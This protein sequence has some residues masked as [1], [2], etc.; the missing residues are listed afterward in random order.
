[1]LA[2]MG[3]IARR[4]SQLSEAQAYLTRALALKVVSHH[5]TTRLLGI[6]VQIAVEQSD[7]VTARRLVQDIE[8]YIEK[9]PK[10]RPFSMF[11]FEGLAHFAESHDVY[12]LAHDIYLK[13][14][15]H[16]EH[17]R[18]FN[19]S[20]HRAQILHRLGNIARKQN[21]YARAWVYYAQGLQF[22]E[23]GDLNVLEIDLLWAWARL[24]H[25]AGHLDTACHFMR[26]ARLRALAGSQYPS[27]IPRAT[28]VR[29]W[30]EER[31]A[32]I[33]PDFIQMGCDD[34]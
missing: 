25:W 4:N 7:L 8:D 30:S 21:D 16:S 19:L 13:A 2:E 6:L 26:L 28:P 34:C 3:Y 9:T 5:F 14:L 29:E 17:Q 12:D 20:L 31:L 32:Q 33:I 18:F 22:C 24:E 1:M 11:Q 10:S 23:Q 27:S 15:R